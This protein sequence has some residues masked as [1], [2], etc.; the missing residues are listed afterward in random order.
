M[1][2]LIRLNSET[3]TETLF[4]FGN[5]KQ[6][7]EVSVTWDDIADKLNDQYGVKY[8]ESYY[9][10]MWRKLFGKEH[11]QEPL[12]LSSELDEKLKQQVSEIEKKKIQLRAVNSEYK[13]WLRQD[14]FN[15]EI[16]SA[17]TDKIQTI[18]PDKKFEPQETQTTDRAVYALLSD[19]HYGLEYSSI[20]GD[21]NTEIAT[22]RIHNYACKIAE[23]GKAHAISDCYVS[24]M[25]DMISGMIHQTLRIETSHDVVEQTMQISEIIA[26]FLAYLC[27]NFAHVYVNNVSGNHS[28]IE[29]DKKAG[30]RSERLD[31]IVI[32]YCKTALSQ[33]DNVVF[34]DNDIDNS[35]ARFEIFGKNYIAVHGDMDQNLKHSVHEI[36]ELTGDKIDYFVYGH[37]HVVNTRFEN[38]GY[39]GNGS[40]AAGGD[41]YTTR[42][43]LFAPAMQ[44][45]MIVNSDGVECM[46]PIKL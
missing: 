13:K 6:N 19:V 16:L 40:I 7:K 34:M 11:P 12:E 18:I 26:Y 2:E 4:R 28:R 20:N 44:I 21:Y 3:L 35:I 32:W 29:P 46:Y 36:R 30:L 22:G 9:R 8:C 45:T 31:E 27:D 10:K 24:L 42:K 14:A 23:I 37:L 41:D 15:Q 25:G 17:L 39:I 1:N 38:V 33:Y 43:R 5:M